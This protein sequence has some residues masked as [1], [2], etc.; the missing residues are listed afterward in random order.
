VEEQKAPRKKVTRHKGQFQVVNTW[1]VHA[2]DLGPGML[3]SFLI[4]WYER[5]DKISEVRH[6][7][8][9]ATQSTIYLHTSIRDR[10]QT[11]YL[12]RLRSKGL[13]EVRLRRNPNRRYLRLNIDA[14]NRMIDETR[15]GY[16]HRRD[17]DIPISDVGITEGMLVEHP[18]FGRCEISDVPQDDRVVICGDD[19]DHHTVN[20]SDLHPISADDDPSD[21]EESATFQG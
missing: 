7:W 14:I 3:L 12:K 11:R 13:V 5:F 15:I 9:F 16:C 19:F 1:L 17:G 21:E 6:G 10:S 2:L 18:K 8:F 4:N 20:T